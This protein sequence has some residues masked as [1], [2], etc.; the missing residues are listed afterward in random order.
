MQPLQPF[1]ASVRSPRVHDDCS[2]A[3]GDILFLMSRIDAPLRRTLSLQAGVALG[4]R[5]RK[6]E[7]L[8]SPTCSIICTPAVQRVS[9]MNCFT[10]TVRRANLVWD[11]LVNI[12]QTVS[13]HQPLEVLVLIRYLRDRS[14]VSCLSSHL[15]HMLFCVNWHRHSGFRPG[16]LMSTGSVTLDSVLGR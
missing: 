11:F 3:S 14:G 1:P 7:G 16:C 8:I 12:T 13:R 4:L 15:K 9:I 10:P 6:K 5:Q 2:A